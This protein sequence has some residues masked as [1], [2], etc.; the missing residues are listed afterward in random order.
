M[1][2][3]LLNL[4]VLKELLHAGFQ[5]VGKVDRHVINRHPQPFNETPEKMGRVLF[6]FTAHDRSREVLAVDGIRGD[7]QPL[8]VYLPLLPSVFVPSREFFFVVA[9]LN[10]PS[11]AMNPENSPGGSSSEKSS[12]NSPRLPALSTHCLTVPTETLTLWNS[13]RS[14]VTRRRESPF[15]KT[16]P[17][18]YVITPGMKVD[19]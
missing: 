10:V 18:A 1:K 8:L 9:D 3:A 13:L 17:V 19:R 14:L 16:L 5:P 15:F 2:D 7:E 11:K 4:V 12:F 6:V